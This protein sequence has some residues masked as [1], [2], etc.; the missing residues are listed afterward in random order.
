MPGLFGQFLFILRS[1]GPGLSFDLAPLF[2][3]LLDLG[4]E[5]FFAFLVIRLGLG[6]FALNPVKLD[7]NPYELGIFLCQL[8]LDFFDFRGS[9]IGGSFIRQIYCFKINWRS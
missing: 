6:K 2:L 5:S 8:R 3:E 1:L 7:V 9:G 4:P